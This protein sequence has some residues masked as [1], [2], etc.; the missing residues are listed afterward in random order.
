MANSIVEICNIAL[1]LVGERQIANATL[2][3]STD[4]ERLCALLYP[5]VR[6]KILRAH[7]WNF[8]EKRTQLAAL[9]ETPDFEFNYYYTLPA[10]CLRLLRLYESDEQYRVEADR[11]IATDATPCKI[12]YTAKIL[13]VSQFDSTFVSCVAY[14]LASELALVLSDNRKLQDDL[15][16]AAKDELS[17]AKMYDAQESYPYKR[18]N[19]NSWPSFRR[20]RRGSNGPKWNGW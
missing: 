15:R 4:A 14:Q 10:D 5:N 17:N 1:A 6:D 13:D 9:V 11:R 19:K 2:S 12:V 16:R 3:D 7:P 18:Q 8:A 20:G